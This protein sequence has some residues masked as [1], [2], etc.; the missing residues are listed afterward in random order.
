MAAAVRQV[1][2]DV[3]ARVPVMNV[4]TLDEVASGSMAQERLMGVA[5]GN[6]RVL[7]LVLASVGLGGLLSVAVAR[8]TNEIGVRMALGARRATVVLMV[9]RET[10]TLVA[11]AVAIGLPCAIAAARQAAS[12][13]FGLSPADPA[14]LAIAIAAL[15]S[16]GA[17]AAYGPARRAAR[18]DPISAL[19]HE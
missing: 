4:T 15:T 16:V 5:L 10:F 9:L 8:R 13:L 3:D 19:R 2:H 14:I 18:I 17:L 1:V 7:A 6:L 12:L 11:V